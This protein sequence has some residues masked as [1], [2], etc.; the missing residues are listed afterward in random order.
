MFAY[1]VEIVYFC[2]NSHIILKTT[3]YETIPIDCSQSRRRPYDGI[4]FFYKRQSSGA[5]LAD[6]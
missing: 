6:S 3:Y 4:L 5:Y 1:L 2:E